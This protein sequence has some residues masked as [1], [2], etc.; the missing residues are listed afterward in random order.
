MPGLMTMSDTSKWLELDFDS[1]AP[2]LFQDERLSLISGEQIVYHY[3]LM[4]AI[5]FYLQPQPLVDVK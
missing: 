5:I 1:S 3:Y 4:L 2:H